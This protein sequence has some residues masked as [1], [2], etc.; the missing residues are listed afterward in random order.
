MGASRA[1]GGRLLG[2]LSDA[3]SRGAGAALRALNFGA[4]AGRPIED[5]FIGIS[6]YICP[7]GGTIDEGIARDAFIETIADLAMSGVAD[8]NALTADQMQ[9]VFEL[10]ASHAIM[11]RLCNDI[12]ANTVAFPSNLPDAQRVQAQLLDFIRGGVAD[13]LTQSK[14]ALQSLTPE[15]AQ[16][17]VETIYEQA[18]RVLETM[19]NQA[20][21]E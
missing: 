16:A 6:D 1:A 8:F 20:E 21:E 13:A 9:T 4:L 18:F 15:L 2:F 14:N 10:Y 17:F 19:G 7:D 3:V 11:A 12:G 5:V